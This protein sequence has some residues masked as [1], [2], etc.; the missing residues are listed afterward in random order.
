MITFLRTTEMIPSRSAEAIGLAKEIAAA[1]SRASGL[2]I[3]VATGFGSE[4]MRIAYIAHAESVAKLDEAIGRILA[5]PEYRAAVAKVSEMFLP[6][7]LRDQ[8][9]K[10]IP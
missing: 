8:V 5:D 4:P 2:Q 6:G 1:A 9:W 7:T 3:S 10:H